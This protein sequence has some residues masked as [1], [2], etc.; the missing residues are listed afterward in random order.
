M[1]TTKHAISTAMRQSL[2]RLGLEIRST[3]RPAS[4]LAG[5]PI[6]FEPTLRAA[7]EAGLSVGDYIDVALNGMPGATQATID[8]MKALNVFAQRID[9]VVEIGPG[10]GRYMEKTLAACTP[11]RYEFYETAQPWALYVERVY[12]G[13]RQPAAGMNLGATA[14]ESA[15]LVQ[16]HNVFSAMNLLTTLRYWPEMARVARPGGF[17]VFDVMT[18]ACLDPDSIDKWTGSGRGSGPYPAAMPRETVQ[19]YFTSRGFSCLGTFLAP[20]GRGKTEVFVFRKD[21]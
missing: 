9:T 11:S 20:L 17:V 1:S 18:E 12:G 10:S 6:A 16:A 3:A 2:S 19:G 14:S 4:E 21:P 13:I 5:P 7:S 8:R 15:D